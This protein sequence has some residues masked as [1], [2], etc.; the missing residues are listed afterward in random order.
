MV[1]IL[2]KDACVGEEIQFNSALVLNRGI[3][4]Y[5][6]AFGDGN[7][8]A[9]ANP[10]HTYM[11][12]GNFTVKL[13]VT[14][15]FG[16]KGDANDYPVQAFEKP[17][18]SFT[19]EYLMSKGMETDWRF[20]F[21]GKGAQ[22]YEWYFEDGQKIGVID[23]SGIDRIVLRQQTNFLQQQTL[24]FVQVGFLGLEVS[25]ILLSHRTEITVIDI[26]GPFFV[27]PLEFNR[28]GSQ[29]QKQSKGREEV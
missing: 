16:C 24:L 17:K 13:S 15:N 21:T 11:A 29:H 4:S 19:S 20:D 26:D 23:F 27:G 10:K 8:S 22:N 3:P 12:Q 6:W 5:N 9:Q 14:S 18:A 25:A 1:S 2:G 28:Q 7:L